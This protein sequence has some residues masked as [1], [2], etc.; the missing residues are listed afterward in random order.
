MKKKIAALCLT[1]A[2]AASVLAGCGGDGK[3]SSGKGEEAKNSTE[4]QELQFW[5]WW[6]SE[7]RKPYIQEMVD[8][9]NESQDKYH[10]TYVDIPFGDIFTK[11]I[12]QIAAGKPCDI[13]ANSMEEVRFRAGESQVEPLDEYLT[14]DVKS[15][16][17][18]QYIDACTGDD[19]SVYALPYSV[20]TRAIFYNKAHFAEAGVNAGE[21]K[22]WDDLVNAARKL[23]KKNGETWER[24][25]FMPML[26]NASVDTWVINANSGMTWFDPETL[27]IKVDTETNREVMKWIRS[28]VE[29]YGQ[30]E[31]DELQ[32]AFGSGMADPFA[33]GTMSML[34]QTSAYTSNLTQTAPDLEYGIIQLPEFKS[35][36]GHQS[37]GGGFVL[38]IP[39]GAKC[40]EGSYEF[41]KYAT[42]KETQDFLAT[43]IGDFSARND[44][45]ESAEFF[46]NPINQEL[47][48]CLEETSTVIVPNKI[49]G[50]Q[51]VLNPLI[52]EGSLGI[53][54]TDTALASA[55]K[56]FENYSGGGK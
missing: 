11:N 18:E 22:T 17:Y 4:V 31:F 45:D 28:Q 9:F 15:A 5:G 32:A 50:Y 16:F 2:M 30:S 7:A 20:D 38:E 42:S 35:G 48:K 3:T 13:I 25:G 36:T 23:D 37:N 21:I 24:V 43:K 12:A 56:A 51:D 14:D 49:K 1:A 53:T 26:G 8:G 39:K 54:D 40:P 27:E 19:G 46:K 52:E 34:V 33:S 55:Q 29:Y 6:S 44:F 41:I 10:V 47:A